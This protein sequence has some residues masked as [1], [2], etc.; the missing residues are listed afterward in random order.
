MDLKPMDLLTIWGSSNVNTVFA[1]RAMDL[2]PMDM[3]FVGVDGHAFGIG[4]RNRFVVELDR[5]ILSNGNAV[6]GAVAI[7]RALAERYVLISPNSR[8]TARTM[9]VKLKRAGIDVPDERIVLAGEQAIEFIAKNYPKARCVIAA[10]R[11]L[12]HAARKAGLVPVQSEADVV[13][14]GRDS[15]WTYQRLALIAN[16]LSRGAVLVGVNSEAAF[17]GANGR[18]VPDTGA[19]LA[20]ITAAT[21]K[22]VDFIIG[23]SLMQAA[24]NRL[25]CDSAEV[26]VVSDKG[27][28]PAQIEA[29]T[30]LGNA[31]AALAY[32]KPLNGFSGLADALQ[33]QPR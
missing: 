31:H 19:L 29:A 24:I 11:V 4:P 27:S 16:E 26:V 15:T 3:Q 25:Q 13:L 6:P 20:S 21:G 28:F 32:G 9:A 33:S 2:G 30:G 7:L 23:P 1:E 17:V 14:V 22:A 18:I 8:D 10:S 5:T 12:S